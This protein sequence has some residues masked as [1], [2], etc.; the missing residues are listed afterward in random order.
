M[1]TSS[2]GSPDIS[3]GVTTTVVELNKNKSE[4]NKHE[5]TNTLNYNKHEMKIE[6]LSRQHSYLIYTVES[7][8]KLILLERL[9]RKT[10]CHS[11]STM[12]NDFP[13]L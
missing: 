1:K 6:C 9:N 5:Y 3:G 4:Q 2:G 12:R 11:Y 13:N 7:C 10:C 8:W